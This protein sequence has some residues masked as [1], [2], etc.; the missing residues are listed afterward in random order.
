[1]RTHAPF[2]ASASSALT[3]VRTMMAYLL[4]V[5]GVV[6][7]TCS[8]YALPVADAP[9]LSCV[10]KALSCTKALTSAYA[11]PLGIPL[12][13]FGVG[14]FLFWLLNLRA[15]HRTGD[16]TYRAALTYAT[17]L[18]AV[19]SLTLGAVMFI[20][21]RAPCLYCLITHVANL[22]SFA[23]LWPVMSWRWPGLRSE[24]A[25]HFAALA[26]I[27]VLASSSVYFADRAR[28]AEAELHQLKGAMF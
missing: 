2:V 11:K 17:G 5:V 26:A 8:I 21:L 4:G 20:V 15:F 28:R 23:L 25:W 24:H 1:M 19:L 12:G 13:V 9:T 6:S 14:Y 18:G 27:A 22:S 10:V 3:P 16:R 7:S